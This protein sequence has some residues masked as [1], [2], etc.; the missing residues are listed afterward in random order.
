MARVKRKGLLI[1]LAVTALCC[2]IGWTGYAQRTGGG[3]VQWEYNIL[4]LP[5]LAA[6]E[7]VETRK[8][9]DRLGAEGWELVQAPP[10]GRAGH[11]YFKRQK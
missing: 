6:L 7:L 4:F 11:Y 10:V 3:R 8:Q 5:D 1:A 9:L 2:V